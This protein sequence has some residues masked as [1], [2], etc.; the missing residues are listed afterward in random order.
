MLVKSP[1]KKSHGSPFS[2]RCHRRRPAE[3]QQQVLSSL[4]TQNACLH[5]GAI[6]H[7]L[8]GVN[9]AV[10]LLA[11]EE[12]LAMWHGWEKWRNPWE[13]HG[14]TRNYGKS[15]QTH[16]FT[17]E[18][19]SFDVVQA[20]QYWWRYVM[21]FLAK[22]WNNSG[23]LTGNDYSNSQLFLVQIHLFGAFSLPTD[24]FLLCLCFCVCLVLFRCFLQ[25]ANP[26]YISQLRG[27]VIFC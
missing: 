1:K 15:G 17:I 2:R 9:A 7:R 26:K 6:S 12:V 3:A 5:C 18:Q 25:A 11:V 23:V 19:W 4:A 21:C 22:Q 14:K 20:W 24:M 8:V 10:R 13:N 27:I 16:G